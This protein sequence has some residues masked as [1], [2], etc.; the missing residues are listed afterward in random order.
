M[1][2]VSIL[3]LLQ[4]NTEAFYYSGYCVKKLIL[5]SH[6]KNIANQ[7]ILYYLIIIHLLLTHVKLRIYII[8]Y[9]I[10][11]S[12]S[13]TRQKRGNFLNLLLSSL[14]VK[15]SFLIIYIQPANTLLV[16]IPYINT[17]GHASPKY[18]PLVGAIQ[19]PGR[20]SILYLKG[21]AF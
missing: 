19:L 16:C 11:L 15:L 6:S 1:T 4:K 20:G 3:Q 18:L 5:R 2:I 17:V 7:C 10:C 8:T 13:A 14:L 21:Q 9:F 12:F